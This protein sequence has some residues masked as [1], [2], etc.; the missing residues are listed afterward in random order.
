MS[1]HALRRRCNLEP[2]RQPPGVGEV[3]GPGRN[4]GRVLPQI[5]GRLD[6]QVPVVQDVHRIIADGEYAVAEWTTHARTV[7]AGVTTVTM[8]VSSGSLMGASRQLP[9]ISTSLTPNRC[10]SAADTTRKRRP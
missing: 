4:L 10:S 1:S 5:F 3:E 7:T 9:N 6:P 8:P 2:A